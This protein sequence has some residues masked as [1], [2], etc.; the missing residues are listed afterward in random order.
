MNAK[1]YH[2]SCL[3]NSIKFEFESKFNSYG[4]CHCRSCRKAS[5]SAFAANIPVEAA[6]FRLISGDSMLQ[7]YESSPNKYRCF[8]S[9]CGSPIYAHVSK[10]PEVL[11]VRLGSLDTEFTEDPKCHYF[12]KERAHWFH[13]ADEFQQFPAWPTKEFL[14]LQ[15][16]KQSDG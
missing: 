5:G 11:R 9:N 10:N 13:I 14:V 8:C 1:K 4:F 3:C 2:G 7:K 15:G 6:R 16:S 12:T